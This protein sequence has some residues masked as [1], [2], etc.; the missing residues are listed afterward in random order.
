MRR[1]CCRSLWF[2]QWPKY[3]VNKFFQSKFQRAILS[4]QLKNKTN[5]GYKTPKCKELCV[6]LVSL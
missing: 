2:P 4:I 3:T 5:K 1:G 6:S